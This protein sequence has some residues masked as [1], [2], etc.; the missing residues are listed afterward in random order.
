MIDP[1]EVMYEE[2]QQAIDKS[3]S[4]ERI[5]DSLRHLLCEVDDER[6][7]T[8]RYYGDSNTP[9][10]DKLESMLEH[11]ER[12]VEGQIEALNPGSYKQWYDFN[13]YA[14]GER[15]EMLQ[16]AF[17]EGINAVA[18]ESLPCS[19]WRGAIEYISE[20]GLASLNYEATRKAVIDYCIEENARKYGVRIDRKEAERIWA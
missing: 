3:H 7:K 16:Y 4:W 5:R 20:H 15:R 1:V 13:F 8:V 19:E 6:R 10:Y 11:V 9:E 12:Y 17:Q 2:D 18:L 14:T